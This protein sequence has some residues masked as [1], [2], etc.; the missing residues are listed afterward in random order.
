MASDGEVLVPEILDIWSY[1][2]LPLLTGP[3][4]SFQLGSTYWSNK[5]IIRTCAKRQEKLWL[6]TFTKNMILQFIG[7][8]DLLA[9]ITL[10]ELNG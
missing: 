10:D 2:S 9:K 7:F 6:K 1:P 3:L 8:P 5:Y 4:R